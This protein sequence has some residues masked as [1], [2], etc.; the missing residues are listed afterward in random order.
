ME[1]CCTMYYSSEIKLVLYLAVV[2]VMTQV[3][4]Y[5]VYKI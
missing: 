4:G 5:N 3:T 1:D 2:K